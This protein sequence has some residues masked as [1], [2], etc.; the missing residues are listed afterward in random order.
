M[1][2][3]RAIRRGACSRR[4]ESA[5]GRHGTDIPSHDEG[6]R[7]L[8]QARQHRAYGAIIEW[9]WQT[10]FC[11]TCQG[12][13]PDEDFPALASPLISALEAAAVEIPDVFRIVVLHRTANTEKDDPDEEEGE[14]DAKDERDEPEY[15]NEGTSNSYE[16]SYS[17]LSIVPFG[18]WNPVVGDVRTAATSTSR[19]IVKGRRRDRDRLNGRDGR[20]DRWLFLRMHVEQRGACFCDPSGFEKNVQNILAPRTIGS[21]LFG[22]LNWIDRP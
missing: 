3:S 21:L 12:L 22:R 10:G 13:A 20:G 5:G 15:K 6:R 8:S 1:P 16:S 17:C 9:P 19:N 18:R 2:G 4:E 11:P 14:T 7:R